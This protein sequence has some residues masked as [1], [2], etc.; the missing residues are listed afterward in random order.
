[1]HPT[2]SK[3]HI[4]SSRVREKRIGHER[5]SDMYAFWF[6]LCVCVCAR[7]YVYNACIIKYVICIKH[8][9]KSYIKGKIYGCVSVCVRVCVCEHVCV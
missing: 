5:D 3:L 8:N 7:L 6:I 4:G 9:I 2:S 1:M